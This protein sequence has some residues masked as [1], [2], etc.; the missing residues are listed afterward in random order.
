MAK[1]YVM[2]LAK[3]ADLDT[4][5]ALLDAR[6][7]WLRAR[8]SDQ[9]STGGTF[10]NR[11][12]NNI[13]RGETWLLED[14]GEAIATITL[15]TEGDSDFWTPDELRERAIYVGKMASKIERQ[16]EGL[17]ALMIRWTQDRAAKSDL[18]IVRWDAWRTNAQLQ[19]YYRSIGAQYVR[20]V[21]VADRW[22]GALFEVPAKADDTLADH[23]VT[24]VEA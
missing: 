24:T 4:V 10:R 13:E 11:L 16:G 5:M 22:S 9:W 19:D 1:P 14:N 12:T 17:G 7:H 18:Y 15:G 3:R 23:L 20:T 21:D 8:G 6:I 2:R